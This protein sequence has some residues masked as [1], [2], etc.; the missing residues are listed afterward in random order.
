MRYPR[1]NFKEI[2]EQYNNI[3][4]VV[5]NDINDIY[6]LLEIGEV[7]SRASG[8]FITT[9]PD[10]NGVR[11]IV[12]VR[13]DGS[14]M[15]TTIGFLV[16]KYFMFEEI[17]KG[18]DYRPVLGLEEKYLALADGRVYSLVQHRFLKP[19]RNQSGWSVINL[20]DRNGKRFTAF[21]ARIVYQAFNGPLDKTKK[22]TF[23]DDDKSNCNI[24]NLEAKFKLK[25]I[26]G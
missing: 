14:T 4:Q 18:V 25:N 8:R 24:N 12:L 7:W 9:F 13:K 26:K 19:S 22:I 6:V 3:R 5:L 15:D 1:K 2:P 10:K 23:K 21:P 20:V 11:T 17:F 16:R